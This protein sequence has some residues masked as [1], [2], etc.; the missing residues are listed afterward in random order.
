MMGMALPKDVGTGELEICHHLSFATSLSRL[1]V[2]ISVTVQSSASGRAAAV[3]IAS[4][5]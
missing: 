4:S 5:F 3:A 2:S 1:P